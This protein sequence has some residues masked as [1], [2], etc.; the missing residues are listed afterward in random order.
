[1]PELKELYKS[2]GYNII[3][4]SEHE[5]LTYNDDL[6]EPG[7]LA[8][9]AFEMGFNEPVTRKIYHFNC[10]PKH[11]GVNENYP[12]LE[13]SLENVNKRIEELVNDGYLVVYNHPVSS[14]HESEEFLGLKGLFAMEI[15][16]NVVEVINRTG[17]SDV[18]YDMMLRNGH[19]LWAISAD[20]CHNGKCEPVFTSIDTPYNDCMGGFVMIRAKELKH[21]NII[22]ALEKGD[23]YSCVGKNGK[24]PQIHSMYIENNIFYADFTPVKSVYLKNSYWHCPHKLSYNDDISHVEFEIDREWKYVRLEITDGNGYKAIGNPFFI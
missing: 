15:Y 8:L 13:Y 23:F 19:K 14:F 4:F 18:Y 12:T 20:D 24:A 7:F 10:F 2:N 3:A 17:W 9:P 22:A 5:K 6:N 16:N 21:E 11:Y 1:M